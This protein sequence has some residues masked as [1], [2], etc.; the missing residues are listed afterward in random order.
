MIDMMTPLLGAP[1]LDMTGLTG[2]YDVTVNIA[3]YMAEMQSAGGGAPLDPL[4]MIKGALEQK[5]GLKL[6]SRKVPLDVL[7]ID[8]AEKVPT[9]N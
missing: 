3:D 4:S 1:I 5:M 6:E 7:V 8:S 2:K 9:E